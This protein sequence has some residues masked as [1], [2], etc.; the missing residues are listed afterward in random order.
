MEREEKQENLAELEKRL[1]PKRRRF[2]VEY[3][4]NGWNG[5]KAAAAA[6]FGKTPESSAVAASRMLRDPDV[7]AYLQALSREVYDQLG[8][9]PERL[10]AEFIR[11]YQRATQAVPVM[12][13]DSDKKT[14]VP[15]GEYQ[16]DAQTAIRVLDKLGEHTGMFVQKVEATQTIKGPMEG[17]TTDELRALIRML[18][19]MGIG[20]E[21]G[22][23]E[24]ALTFIGAKDKE[25][26]EET[27]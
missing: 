3:L 15:S 18:E 5:T 20:T 24:A 14:Y 6:G 1:T 8:L 12:V 4:S 22:V 10:A 2:A 23:N 11:L 9:S 16:Y 13:W 7:R 21:N 27:P 17:L 26:E 19:K 25:P